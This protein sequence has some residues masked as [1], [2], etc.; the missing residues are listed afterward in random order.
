[1]QDRKVDGTLCELQQ[2]HVFRERFY[3]FYDRLILY[4]QVGNILAEKEKEASN[5]RV[6]R[7]NLDLGFWF[8][9][10]NDLRHEILLVPAD[11]QLG[12]YFLKFFTQRLTVF[13]SHFSFSVLSN[14][15]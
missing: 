4:F 8:Y 15:I 3:L 6:K 1:M 5:K 11:S 7:E 9:Y 10:R 13:I 12:W 2:V 14:F